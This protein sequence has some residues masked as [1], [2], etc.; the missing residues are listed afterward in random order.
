MF[1]EYLSSQTEI[2]TKY[3]R[4]CEAMI[5]TA[6]I[7]TGLAPLKKPPKLDFLLSNLRGLNQTAFIFTFQR[8]RKI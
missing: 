6:T 2:R 1:Y 8:L 4:K 5:K 3:K 7:I